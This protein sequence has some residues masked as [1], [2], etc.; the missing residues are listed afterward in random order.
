MFLTMFAV[1]FWFKNHL[2]M[3]SLSHEVCNVCC[4]NIYAE[5]SF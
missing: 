4:Y 1:L 3:T 5:F 2:I